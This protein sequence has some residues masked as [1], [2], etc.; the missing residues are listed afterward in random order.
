MGQKCKLLFS[1]YLIVLLCMLFL[2]SCGGSAGNS[3]T[4][5]NS[6]TGKVADGYLKG[7]V[8]KDKDTGAVIFTELTKLLPKSAFEEMLEAC[9]YKIPRRHEG[10]GLITKCDMCIDR[11]KNGLVPIC[12]KT[13]PTGAMNFGEREEMLRLAKKR[14][15]ELKKQYPKAQLVDADSV[16]VIYL[17]IDEP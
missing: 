14:L 11:V 13:C 7:A 10:T 17:I 5:V 3:G 6:I 9:P 8:I 2:L 15:A 12:V 4:S 16:S 1:S